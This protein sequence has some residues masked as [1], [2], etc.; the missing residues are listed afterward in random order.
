MIESELFGLI[1]TPSFLGFDGDGRI[2]IIGEVVGRG[3]HVDLAGL[4]GEKESF[5][6]E[7]GGNP[8]RAFV[9]PLVE[10][11][12]GVDTARLLVLFAGM[13]GRGELVER[14]GSGREEAEG[15]E[16]GATDRARSD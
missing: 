13:Q 11:H 8:R 14:N 16:V 6:K 7:I 9:G 15:V 12:V 5:A 2:V 10:V 4:D 1:L 3:A